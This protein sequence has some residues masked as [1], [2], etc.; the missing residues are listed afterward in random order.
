MSSWLAWGIFAIAAVFLGW[1]GYHFTVRTL[2]FAAAASVVTVVVLV[3]GYG[4]RHPTRA[5]A[6]LVNAFIRGMDDLSS[7][8][9]QPLLPG[10]DVPVPG[11]VGWLVIIALLVFAYRELEVWAMRWQP[12]AVDISALGGDGPGTQEDSRRDT[13]GGGGPEE[14][15]DH[16]KLVAELRFRLPA[17]EVRAPPIL[18]GGTAS[19][20]LASVAENSDVAGSG[21]AGAIIRLAGMLWPAPRRYQVRVW[22]WAK[23]AGAPTA[24]NSRGQERATAGRC[25]TVDL[26]DA[27]AGGSIA[28]KTLAAR[29]LDDAAA[30]VAAYVAR[31]IFKADPT[32]PPWSVGSF[33]GSDLAAL[34]RAKQQCEL[35]DCPQDAHHARRRQIEE[36]EKAVCNSPG[37]GVAR[38][39]LALLY[40][41]EGRHAEALW[42]HAINRKQYPRFFRGRYRLGMSL[43]MIAN[44]G[45]GTLK[46]KDADKFAESLSILDQCG[47]TG[48]AALGRA[49]LA[50]PLSRELRK[51]LL[52]AAR[53]ELH[54]CLRQLTLWRLIWATFWHRDERAMRKPF[55][56]LGERQRFQD[57]ARVAELLVAV[58]QSLNE[59][60]CASTGED[61]RQAIKARPPKRA[62]H[63]M[64]AIAG[65]NAAIEAVGDPKTPAA[66]EVGEKRWRPGANA[67]KTRW[68]PWQRR[69]PSWQAA[70]NAA[71]LYAVLAGSDR[72]RQNEK[73]LMDWAVVSLKRVVDDRHC[74]MER[75]WDWISQ[76]PDLRCLKKSPVFRELLRKQKQNDYPRANPGPDHNGP[77][78][79]GPDH[80]GPDH[81][82]PDHNGTEL[83]AVAR[84]LTCRATTQAGSPLP[85]PSLS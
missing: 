84:G 78:H 55:W 37:A 6:D 20:G 38:Y 56:R 25:V 3:T 68:L 15:R 45:F 59:Q 82:G 50:A 41:L 27:Q 76:D 70:Y 53:S 19:T 47:V 54:E 83:P 8:F 39:E 28:T 30:R 22:V 43:E 58:R 16:D 73:D 81:H 26:E 80:H 35:I 48:G 74:E 57:G 51:E 10:H 71:C 7:A 60:E 63:I 14:K 34:L 11:Q 65:G 77:D 85:Q 13:P 29:D 36:L 9:F 5:P 40:D 69:T 67:E 17:V 79:H 24:A 31:Q 33:D 23:P 32:A 49:G 1:V 46:K 72:Y 62:L 18:P 44:P 21:L 52:T 75:P 61:R 2:R 4:V 42:L 66:P 12:P 64:A